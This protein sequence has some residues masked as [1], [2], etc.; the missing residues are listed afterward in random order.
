MGHLPALDFRRD[1]KARDA[2]GGDIAVIR[3]PGILFEASS[4]S[5][6]RSL[7]SGKRLATMGADQVIDRDW[8][9][10]CRAD[11][12]LLRVNRFLQRPL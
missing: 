1:L 4:R 9:A 8:A 3:I 11:R 2:R 7:P 5:R 10:T 6:E 12:F